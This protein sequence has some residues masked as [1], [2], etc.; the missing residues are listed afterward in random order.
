[1]PQRSRCV[2]TTSRH[3]KKSDGDGGD[4]V[5]ARVSGK[6]KKRAPKR[7]LERPEA[8]RSRAQGRC[9]MTRES[10]G[11]CATVSYCCAECRLHTACRGKPAPVQGGGG[12]S[13][14]GSGAS[15]VVSDCSGGPGNP[16]MVDAYRPLR[17]RPLKYEKYF[18][19]PDGEVKWIRK[20]APPGP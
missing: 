8:E 4:S 18:R 14:A 10:R 9:Y 17:R 12:G 16:G 5:Y 2:T 3:T 19:F 7:L 20:N 15:A 6:R 11:R 13:S 1:M